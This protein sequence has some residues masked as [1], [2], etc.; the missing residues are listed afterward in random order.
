MKYFLP[1]LTIIAII[2]SGC[3]SIPPTGG[4]ECSVDSDCGGYDNNFICDANGDCTACPVPQCP[5]PEE[6]CHYEIDDSARCPSCGE[7]KCQGTTT[8][9]TCRD[10]KQN[11]GE[12]GVDCGGPCPVCKSNSCI[13]EDSIYVRG[14]FEDKTD[15]GWNMHGNAAEDYSI[16]I[17]QDVARTGTHSVRVDLRC[18]DKKM[19]NGLRAEIFP[20]SPSEYTVKVAMPS[21][22]WYGFSIYLP[23]DFSTNAQDYGWHINVAQ[24]HGSPDQDIGEIS[25]SPPLTL[26][27]NKKYSDQPVWQVSKRVDLKKNSTNSGIGENFLLDDIRDDL[28]KWTDWVFHVKWSIEDDGLLQV[29]KNG[30][31]VIDDSG[32]IGFNDDK[33]PYFKSGIYRGSISYCP[34]VTYIDAFTFADERGSYD[35]VAPR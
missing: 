3:V 18:D 24:W 16:N 20:N 7:L 11:Q 4:P 30:E 32:P 6:G 33:G 34:I 29:W 5:Q 26:W 17:V 15:T 13:N 23:E 31:L 19:A 25:R 9:P 12:T 21:E 2:L 27:F 8:P 22:Q 28:G 10:G 1:I 35:C 14:D